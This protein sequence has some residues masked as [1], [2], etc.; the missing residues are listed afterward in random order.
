MNEFMQIPRFITGCYW[1]LS[2]SRAIGTGIEHYL[3][4]VP[5][6]YRT[7][8]GHTIVLEKAQLLG[9]NKIQSLSASINNSCGCNCLPFGQG[10]AYNRNNFSGREFKIAQKLSEIKRNAHL[11]N[12]IFVTIIALTVQFDFKCSPLV[13]C[14]T[15]AAAVLF[16]RYSNRQSFKDAL[17]VCTTQEK[18]GYLT[19]LH[20]KQ[21]N[22]VQ[23]LQLPFIH[24][25]MKLFYKENGDFRY[26]LTKAPLSQRI[27][28]LQSS[29]TDDPL[30]DSRFRTTKSAKD[31]KDPPS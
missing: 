27:Q 2:L 28:M 25:L 6:Y 17:S 24:V 13:L 18:K 4:S 23:N 8:N 16:K 11:V 10:I 15:L 26:E 1:F 7:K 30:N 9:I 5:D 12:F 29:I 31:L 20:D 22:A 19:L 14:T 3:F 21:I